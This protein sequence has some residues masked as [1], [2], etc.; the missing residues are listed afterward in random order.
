[1]MSQTTAMPM[2][3]QRWT[4]STNSWKGGTTQYAATPSPSTMPS[5]RNVRFRFLLACVGD[6]ALVASVRRLARRGRDPLAPKVGARAA[7]DAS[8]RHRDGPRSIAAMQEDDRTPTAGLR[9]SDTRVVIVRADCGG[10]AAARSAGQAW[11]ARMRELWRI[12]SFLKLRMQLAG[13]QRK[14]AIRAQ[15][16]AD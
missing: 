1:M 12:A 14:L 7:L 4:A 5:A 13:G 6:R 2:R 11:Q 15:N 3:E 9:T 10:C 8:S 16:R